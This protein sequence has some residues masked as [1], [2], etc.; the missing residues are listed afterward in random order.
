MPRELQR[1]G[2]R[3][4]LLQ[5][6]DDREARRVAE[7]LRQRESYGVEDVVPGAASVLVSFTDLAAAEASRHEILALAG[8][9]AAPEPPL[10]HLVTIR[11]SY[12]GPDLES[13]ASFLETSVDDVVARHLAGAYHV[14]FMGFVPGFGYLRDSRQLLDVPRRPDPRTKVPAGAVAIAGG[15]SAVYPIASPGGWQL[16]GRTDAVMFDPGRASPSLLTAG[17]RVR[18]VAA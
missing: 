6:E 1:Y 4:W 10:G 11:V 17:C 15:M 7:H 13:V 12:D 2:D 9:L 14:A 5:C 8:D 16:I 18:F 3:A